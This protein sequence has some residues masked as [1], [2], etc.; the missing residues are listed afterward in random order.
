VEREPRT[1][2]GR[3]AEFEPDAV[4]PKWIDRAET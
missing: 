4:Q 2:L 3:L 1:L